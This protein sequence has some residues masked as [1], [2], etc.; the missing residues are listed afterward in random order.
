MG[1][2]FSKRTETNKLCCLLLLAPDKHEAT[3]SGKQL[4]LGSEIQ[5]ATHSWKFLEL[6]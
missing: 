2:L 1:V 5:E 6:Y 3:A 4:S